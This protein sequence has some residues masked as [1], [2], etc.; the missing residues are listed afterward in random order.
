MAE[1]PASPAFEDF[2]RAR[3]A[4]VALLIN[5]VAGRDA[6]RRAA[7]LAAG[8][9]RAAGLTVRQFSGAS[10]EQ[11]AE[12]ARTAV[13]DGCDALIARGGG[14]IVRTA[15]QAV[16]GTPHHSGSSGRLGQ[17]SFP[18]RRRNPAG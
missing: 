15:L 2:G 3:I 18:P 9:L 10:V 4:D 7:E 8:L 5:P 1:Q 11:S 14:G 12:F 6:G 17:S 16:A 13:A